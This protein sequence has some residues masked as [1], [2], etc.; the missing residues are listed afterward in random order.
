[1]RKIYDAIKGSPL[2][3]GI[4]YSDFEPML[5]CLSARTARYKKNG[6]ILLSG[7]KI[8]FVGLVVSGKAQ[9]IKEDAEGR[10]AI[11]GNI[12]EAEIF[13][14]AFACAGITLSPVTVQ[15]AENSE[16]LFIDYKKIVTTCSSACSYHTRLIENMLK[17]IA[18]K[19]L[20]LNQKI[21]IL[22]KRTT[23]E[24]LICYFD[25]VRGSEKKFTIPFN[26]QGLA[27]YLCV[28]RSA[29]SGELCRMRDEGLIK[30]HMNEFEITGNL[31]IGCNV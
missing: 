1:L 20:A 14:E 3:Q 26:R 25:S 9:I 23:R 5:T 15:A 10:I 19:N 7:N 16:I 27:Y 28:D 31:C 18:F 29:M 21:E 4:E 6:I 11:M 24:K 2:F 17:L 30:F 22:S 13:G 8:D 12:V